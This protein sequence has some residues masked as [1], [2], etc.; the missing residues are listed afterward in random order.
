MYINSLPSHTPDLSAHFGYK[1]VKVCATLLQKIKE[2]ALAILR[3]FGSKTWSLPGL[4]FR[5]P[6]VTIKHLC[7]KD[8]PL[9]YTEELF[10]KGYTRFGQKMLTREE[11]KPY[12]QYAALVACIH[13]GEDSDWI[14]PLGIQRINPLTL[15]V[16]LPGSLVAHKNYFFD[17]Q[18]GLKIALFQREEDTLVVFGALNSGEFHESGDVRTVVFNNLWTSAVGNLLGSVSALYE[19]ADSAIKILKRH[20]AFTSTL[21]LTG[22]CLG[23]SLASYVGLKQ[24]IKTVSFNTLPLGAGLQQALGEE[25]LRDAEEYITHISA[26]TDR[27]SHLPA[28]AGLFDAAVNFLGINTP[29]NFGKKYLIP[30]AYTAYSRDTHWYF[31]GSLMKHLGFSERATTAAIFRK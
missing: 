31:T 8:L 2:V 9:S 28:I 20:C 19:Q 5:F 22:Q 13:N 14:H 27:L 30:T 15:N 6:A 17:E 21:I 23:G 16:S 7:S 12:L 18:S 26:T 11:T 29:G 4:I 25:R 3:Y 1:V 10:G 24:Q